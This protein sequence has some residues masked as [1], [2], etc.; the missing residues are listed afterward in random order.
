MFQVG[1]LVE[2]QLLS[3]DVLTLRY[4][5]CIGKILYFEGYLR[6]VAVMDAYISI[7]NNKLKS[8]EYFPKIIKDQIWV[9]DNYLT[10]LIGLPD[11]GRHN[12]NRFSKVGIRRSNINQLVISDIDWTYLVLSAE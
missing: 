10:S 8:L 1:D 5:T 2:Y 11:I 9:Q 3:Q 7:A 12:I 4:L 6:D